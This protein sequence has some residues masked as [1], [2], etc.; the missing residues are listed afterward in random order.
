MPELAMALSSLHFLSPDARSKAFDAS[1]NGYARGE[2]AA[3]VVLKSLDA[4]LRDGN[5]IR[6]VIRGT[7]VNQDGRTPGITVPS[8][9]S[10]EELIR[11]TY[12]SAGLDFR[13]TQYFEA[14]GTGTPVG[15]PLE[16]SAIGATFGQSRTPEQPTI[17]V[18]SVKT[19]IGHLEAAAGLAGLIKA[20][21][22][23]EKG[24]VPANLWFEKPNPRIDMEAWKLKV[25]WE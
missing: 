14:H 5:V 19:N 11:S 7:G 15:D 18:G 22:C 10:Q 3:V 8:A 25:S 6:A 12:A 13:D 20:V 2:G 23:V 16:C 24:Q 9:R 4:A 1:A 21:Y 17:L